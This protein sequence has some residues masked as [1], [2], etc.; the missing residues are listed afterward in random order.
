MMLKTYKKYILT[1]FCLSVIALGFNS[2]ESTRLE[3]L[4]DPNAL[5]PTEAD[6]DLFLNSIE[7]G[8]A[9]FFDGNQS[10]DNAAL[11]ERGMEVT[12]M[13]HMFGPTYTNAYAPTD[14]DILYEDAYAG[15]LAD[16]RALVPIAEDAGLFTHVGIAKTIEAY[17]IMTLV[18][19]FGDLP[20]S[21]AL[22]GT[23]FPN[24][25]LDDDAA[26]YADIE[27][28]LNE[29]I[30][31]FNQEELNGA[32]NDLFYGGDETKWIAFAN[33]L[34]LKLYIQTR[35][36]DASVGAKINTLVDEGNIIL[37]TEDDFQFNYSSTDA[38]PDSRHPFFGR[39]FDVAADV[40]DYMSNSYMVRVKDDYPSGD[41]R[42]RYYFY[43]QSLDFTVDPN[44]NECITISRPTHYSSSDTFCDP[45]N[46]YW[47]RDHADNDGI[48]PDGALRTTW[49]VY[50]IGGLF[51]DS[52]GA[53][54]PGR[55][56][57]LQGAG[58]S[59]IMLASFTNFMLAEGVLTAGVSG[60]AREYLE[61][62][63]R[64]SISKVIA[65][66]EGL[67][68]LDDVVVADNPDTE[69]VNEERTVRSIYVPTQGSIDTYVTNVLDEF[70]A[71]SGDGRLEIVVN[72][73]FKA[74]FGNGIEAYNTYRRTGFPSDLQPTLLEA[75]GEFI[76]SFPYPSELALQNSNVSQKPD[77]A[78]RVFWAE[79]GPTVD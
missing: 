12:R 37:N 22:Q 6:P 46:G 31:S 41:P 26:I 48:P 65:F 8:L 60:D 44:E 27:I 23:E 10:D 57:G 36:V 14:F 67:D 75:S 64:T 55:N 42:A 68:Y 61:A 34:K 62:G 45:G 70:D 43:R 63:V 21:Q 4:E 77:Q 73:Y 32:P 19:N 9:A 7:V 76:N 74:L 69:D 59:P 79:G 1:A 49:G 5:S 51:D 50:P 56:I 15:L 35:L 53:A 3:I 20:Y 30:A 25:E 38:N 78:V 28:L 40:D 52:R 39:N 72:E 16:T 66:G 18:D 54:I 17:T 47:G 58:L 33:T 24:P 13:L 11:S 71:A 29:A 2:C